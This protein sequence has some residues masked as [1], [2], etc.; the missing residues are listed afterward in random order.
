MVHRLR[1]AHPK[2]VIASVAVCFVMVLTVACGSDESGDGKTSA[3]GAK[4]AQIPLRMGYIGTAD[5]VLLSMVSNGSLERNGFDVDVVKFLSGVPQVAAISKGDI[6][7]GYVAAPPLTSMASQGVGVRAIAISTKN[8][9]GY[10]LVV[11]KD[12]DIADIADLKGKTV[13]TL[14]GSNLEFGLNELLKTVGLTTKDVKLVNIQTQLTPAIFKSGGVDAVY[15]NQVP[16]VQLESAGAKVIAFQ[17]EAPKAAGASLAFFVPR[18]EYLA[19]HP[20]AAKRFLAAV[21]E[22]AD[23]LEKRPDLAPQLYEKTFGISKAEAERLAGRIEV[24]PLSQQADPSY[25]FNLNGGA[26]EAIRPVVDF[27]LGLGQI[28]ESIDPSKLI[29]GQYVQAAADED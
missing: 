6:D 17:D 13:A 3:S 14:I 15:T 11:P 4:D 29:D 25:P 26:Q 28:K 23:E 10:G 5:P 9:A 22:T 18:D 8:D 7:I 24:V 12:S 27:M 19:E 16:V 1:W 21:R 20:G 2:V